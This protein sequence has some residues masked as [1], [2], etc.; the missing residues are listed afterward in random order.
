LHLL[1]ETLLRKPDRSDAENLARV[2]RRLKESLG[3]LGDEIAKEAL[4]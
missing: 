2:I 1:L 3:Q 4:L